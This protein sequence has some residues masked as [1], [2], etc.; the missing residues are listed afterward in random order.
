MT[1]KYS[2]KQALISS[3]LVLALCCTML[4][5]TTFAWFTDSVSSANN[6]IKSGNLDVELE[7]WN[8]SAWVDVSGKSDI[9]T[10]EYWEPGVTE[11]A[12]L[13]VAN[14]GSLAL[15]YQLGI[16]I[17]SEIAGKNAAGQEFKLSD[18]IF[19]DVIEGV[20]GETG[21]YANRDAALA[22]I[23]NG[24]KISA[25]YT[26]ASAMAP[27]EELYLALVVYMPTSVGN[28]ANH[29]GT[30]EP[31]IEL[32]INVIATQLAN[33][34]DSFGNDY[35]ED[36]WHPDMQVYTAEDLA[37]AV[38]S[39]EPGT[40]I[41]LMDTVTL[42]QPLV[43]PAA[44]SA[45]TYSMRS[46]PATTTI[47]LNG[48]AIIGNVEK[49][50]GH[51]I[52]NEGNLI[53]RNGTVTSAANNGGS[54]IYNAEGAAIVL[55][56]LIVSGA[57]QSG[58]GWPSYAIN[59]Y[60]SMYITEGVTVTSN[61]GAIAIYGD[62][63]I[64]D[65]DVIMNGFGGSSHVFYI[66]GE[67]TNVTIN[68]GTYIHKGNV[69][70]S[71][72]YI[73]T[74]ASL[75]INGGYFTAS[76]G[77][78][79]LAA[80]KGSLTVNGGMFDNA[81]LDWGGPITINGGTYK[82]QPGAK[83]IPAG[84]KCAKNSDGNWV[85]TVAIQ[86]PEDFQ[87]ALENAKNGE[88]ITLLQDIVFTTGVGSN[89][90]S[91]TGD[92]SFTIDLN[93]HT[94]TSNLGGNALRF[95]IGEGNDVKDTTVTI[96]IKNGTVISESGNW[97]AISA[98]TADNSGN[99]IILNLED[100]TVSASKAGD[101]AIKSWAGATINAT[102]VTAT[103]SYAGCFYA[104]G[105]EMVLNN[106]TAIQTGLH[107][108]PYMSMAVAVSGGGKMTV[109]SGTYSTTPSAASD[110]YNQGSSHG[111]WC[112][113]VMNSGGTLII[114]G[115]TF[116]NGNFGEDSLAT[117]ARGLIFGD[118]ASVVEINGGTFNAL[119][120]V[121]DYQNNL[122][123]QPNPNFLISGGTFSANPTAVT[124][125]G[126][127]TVADGY[128][129][130]ENNGV[131]T[132]EQIKLVSVDG[133]EY[134]SL[135]DAVN[136]ANGKTVTLLRDVTLKNGVL[137]PEGATVTI[138]LNGHSISMIES[139]ITTNYAIY[140]I[141]NLTLKDSVGTG[142]VNARGIYNGYDFDANI[143]PG[144]VLTV[145]SGNYNAKGTNGGAC[146]FNYGTAYINGGSFTSVGGYSLNNQSG[147]SMTI[148]NANANNG[149]YTTGATLT[150]NGGEIYGNRSGCH[151]LYAWNS[152][153]TINNG[154]F[155][156]NNSGNATIMA[157]GTTVMTIKDGTFGIK[158]GRVPGNGNTWTSCL[159]DT[160]NTAVLTVDGGTFNGGVRVQSG[161]TM[162][163]NGGSFNDSYGSNYNIYGTV[164][165]KGGSFTDD[166]A[167]N[168]ANKYLA[169][170]Y[171]LDGNGVV[172]AK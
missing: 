14:A 99:H 155:Y 51:V 106:C 85:V 88:V 37:A 67:G 66:G 168:F 60:G 138:E 65:A 62:T 146:V 78:Y 49:S 169:D 13:R 24:K 35:D 71:L 91:Y 160:A 64:D 53:L 10:N 126:G 9:L 117:A 28:E 32:G 144:A 45:A 56:D 75:T 38:S 172:S 125:Y 33:E 164:S 112:A 34:N 59:S 82:T 123:I 18:Y 157:A 109:N 12:Y 153:V 21:A 161:T 52:R 3:I 40:E 154:T 113:G 70:G 74:G 147:A 19:F 47:D 92:K 105:G 97:C 135:Q 131:W 31:E 115:G 54:A 167:K 130:V 30:D 83:Y 84:Y 104:V 151:V 98:S 68:G 94:V 150:V 110:A 90:I 116:S 44:A 111:S 6:V 165:V 76:N 50:V 79:G 42:T 20:N 86:S 145:E 73:M 4:V 124:S 58:D 140:N 121:I 141:G 143:F 156:N 158:D 102:N 101:Y 166:T 27:D 129:V 25:G 43:I 96:T 16:N 137:I 108:A 63:V 72:A 55:E 26:K 7:Y 114:N 93:G 22:A 95:K 132:V 11:I 41:V 107:T 8:G 152:I 170:G 39:A 89:G 127:V 134:G 163:I 57:P 1:K 162:N 36:A 77:G 136:A 23:A 118:T 122:G 46:T 120:S 29:N 119:K 128:E 133:V 80:Y 159:T 69:D 139:L 171:E 2:T 48:N 81:F 103:G 5:G 100:L 148:A 87:N 142:S 61:H 15:K 17:I 149:I